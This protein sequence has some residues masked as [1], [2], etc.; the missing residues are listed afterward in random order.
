MPDPSTKDVPRRAL[1]TREV[2]RR[3]SSLRLSP[4]REIEIVDE[5]SQHLEDHYGE[6]I[7]GGASPEE[8]K[9]VALASFRSGSVLAQHLAPLRQAHATAPVALGA[10]TGQVHHDL[11][12]DVC[13]A[14][15]VF[16]KQPGF[17][18]VAA[19]TLAIGIG[20]NTAIFSVVYG[21]LLK[22]LPFHDPE[23]LVS[24]WH[25]APGLNLPQLEQGAATY[26]T[27]RESNRVFEDI[28]VWDRE[29]VS[30]TGRG[31]PERANALWV[32][33]GLFP[34]LRV[35][36]QL[37][38][39]FAKE[40]DAPG[41]PRRAILSYGYWQRRFGGAQDVIGQSLNV[42]GRP[43]EVIGILPPSF[44]FLHT[45]PAVLLP[46]RFNR[47][48]VRLGDFSYRAVA[49][50][51]PGVTLE[52]ANA[53]VA[54]M[55]P[56]ALDRFPMWHG[57]T[58]KMWDAA[59]LGPYVRP[60]AQDV[61]GD[62]GRVL[63]ILAGAVGIVLLMACANVAN[64]FL[65]R[66]EGRQQELAV[67][68][69]LGASRSRIARQLLSESVGLALTGGVLGLVFAWSGLVHLPAGDKRARPGCISECVAR[70]AFGRDA[71]T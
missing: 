62:V 43:Y 46:F 65:V 19:L 24:V 56:L 29:E 64:L 57:F 63:W 25:R 58:R 2:R 1:W 60:L 7:T 51:K 26:F 36:P 10:T 31:D 6:L 27:Y 44:K 50:L 12:Q 70:G 30:I 8:A 16:R 53:D 66:A 13:Y 49:R 41:S 42:N 15:R 47:A 40:D 69:A 9:R 5:L 68:A 67:R 52:Q 21:V 37:G 35:Q 34:I 61:I 3:L 28:A 71:V 45:D 11:W 20:A 32:T 4:T 59:Q 48:E 38:R 39:I 18:V 23:R 14:V 54:R 55:I 22:P 17:S 33:D